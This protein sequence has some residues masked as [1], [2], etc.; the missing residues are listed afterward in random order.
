MNILSAKFAEASEGSV[1]LRTEEAGAV[2]ISVFGPDHSGG[3]RAAWEEWGGD[4]QPFEPAPG[5]SA[6][7]QAK[8]FVARHFDGLELL[9]MKDWRDS[10]PAEFTPKLQACYGWVQ[11]VIAAA[12]AGETNFTEPPHTFAEVLAEISN[13]NQP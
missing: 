9:T 12:A 10:V 1:V 7:E 6:I 3:W 13:L 11:G 8:S 5:P 4:T 2:L